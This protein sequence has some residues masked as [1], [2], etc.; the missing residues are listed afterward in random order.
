[1]DAAELFI[2]K[3]AQDVPPAVEE[4]QG[5]KLIYAAGRSIGTDGELVCAIRAGENM[6]FDQDI[7]ILWQFG[8][9][10][11]SLGHALGFHSPRFNDIVKRDFDVKWKYGG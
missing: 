6:V 7:G 2:V 10:P 5:T 3:V 8:P 9:C 1:M 4:H 11:Q